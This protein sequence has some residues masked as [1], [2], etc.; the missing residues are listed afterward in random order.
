MPPQPY[1]PRWI[2]VNLKFSHEGSTMLFGLN[3]IGP[4]GRPT[5]AQLI[6][7]CTSIVTNIWPGMQAYMSA[8]YQLIMVE[9]TDRYDVGGAY[10]SYTPPTPQLGTAA[11]DS[12]PANVAL[13]IS[14]KT[15]LSGRTAHGRSYAFGFVDT[16]FTGSAAV[17]ALI[18]QLANLAQTL[19]TYGGGI[20]IAVDYGVLSLK[21]DLLRPIN[22]YAIDSIADSQRR[23]LPGRGY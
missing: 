15:G 20:G 9:A 2:K 6:T 1:V 7:L 10:G 21:D 13:C 19:I 11:G 8:G 3:F 4:V 18:V 22:G 17:S 23:R 5:E 12:L 14:W 16:H